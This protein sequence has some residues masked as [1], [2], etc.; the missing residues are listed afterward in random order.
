MSIPTGQAGTQGAVRLRST[1]RAARRAESTVPRSGL[2]PAG[3]SPS[4][5]EALS[6]NGFHAAPKS[7]RSGLH[8]PIDTD[9]RSPL[10][11]A[12]QP[13]ANDVAVAPS[14]ERFHERHRG[15]S[16][17]LIT[18]F[19]MSK[20]PHSGFF[21]CPLRARFGERRPFASL[22]IYESNGN[23]NPWPMGIIGSRLIAPYI[24]FGGSTPSRERELFAVRRLRDGTIG[25]RRPPAGKAAQ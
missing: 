24:R 11:W 1:G 10:E 7:R 16:N 18:A 14:A 13:W 21:S 2:S 3:I 12:K 17:T 6:G 4:A 19:V 9:G 23:S 15:Q 25:S 8:R 5:M 22:G 20:L